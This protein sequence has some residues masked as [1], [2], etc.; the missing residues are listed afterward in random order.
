MSR[1]IV[2]LVA[3]FLWT[4]TAVA[5]VHFTDQVGNAAT[6]VADN[7]ISLDEAVERVRRQTGGKVI[8]AET[9][10]EGNRRVHVIKVL[11]EDGRVQ[12]FRIPAG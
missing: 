2:L 12:T 1:I 10:R 11:T 3:A 9:V 5:G 7:G 8:R 6:A 4:G